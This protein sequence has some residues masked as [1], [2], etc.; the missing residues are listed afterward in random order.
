MI[1]ALCKG[2]YL[3][4][5]FHHCLLSLSL[6]LGNTQTQFQKDRY[7]AERWQITAEVVKSILLP[8]NKRWHPV[9]RNMEDLFQRRSL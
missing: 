2:S 8:K 3:S 7:I 5:P 1:M 4:C 9:G 6:S